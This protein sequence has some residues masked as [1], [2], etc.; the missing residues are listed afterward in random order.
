MLSI[1]TTGSAA[2]CNKCS[3]QV[4][5]HA[6]VI[7]PV[8][9]K[10]VDALDAVLKKLA[11]L[12]AGPANN[13]IS[14]GLY[15]VRRSLHSIGCGQDGCGKAGFGL[16]NTVQQWTVGTGAI[17]QY[18]TL[19]GGRGGQSSY[20]DADVEYFNNGGQVAPIAAT[21]PVWAGEV[22][23]LAIGWPGQPSLYA[24]E[25][26]SVNGPGAGGANPL[27]VYNGG[28]GGTGSLSGIG[29]GGGG[30]ATV[31]Q[32]PNGAT[33]MIAGGGG[34]GG[35]YRNDSPGVGG[36]GGGQ[37]PAP[38]WDNVVWPGGSGSSGNGDNGGNGGPG[39]NQTDNQANGN[40]AGGGSAEDLSGN[41]GG[42]GGGGG[43]FGGSGGEAGTAGVAPWDTAGPG[44]GGGAGSSY[45]NPLLTS[46]VSILP[47][48]QYPPGEGGST[49]IIQW[50]DIQ[51][52]ALNSLR[53]GYNAF[54]KLEATYGGNPVGY[55]TVWQVS[56]G[57]LPNGLTLSPAGVLLGSPT[58]S[59]NYSFE[60]TV[61]GNGVAS[62]VHTYE[63]TVWP[64]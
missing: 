64:G 57:S 31:I 4:P 21:V 59:G 6:Q 24:S 11:Y 34:G 2:T 49:A 36:T 61:T 38:A 30:A 60:V 17:S 46:N 19:T 28:P 12:P 14:G 48:V 47:V 50:V 3:Q 20:L 51:T 52:P 58:Q 41:G 43:F 15:T 39:G 42:G 10:I 62:S 26:S 5:K 1:P 53:V 23:S 33:I 16:S 13:L 25:E 35:G 7:T 27:N 18:F 37:P 40:G 29:G 54:Q 8:L 44:G 32:D 56:S 55:L 9:E 63:G 45:A 22:L